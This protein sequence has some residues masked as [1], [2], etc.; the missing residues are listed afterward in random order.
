MSIVALAMAALATAV[1][2]TR[3]YA[4]GQGTAAQHARVVLAR[5]R[6]T[7]EEAAASADFPGMAVLSSQVGSFSFPDTLVVWKP[8]GNPVNPAGPPLYNELVIYCPDPA[9]PNRLLEITAPTD[10]R[11][12]PALTDTAA[13]QSNINAIK[14]SNAAVKTI[15]T[16]MLRVADAGS[17][18]SG[19]GSSQLRAALRFSVV[20]RPS[21]ADWTNY[22]NGTTAWSAL[23]WVQGINGSQAGLRQAW[24]RTELQLVSTPTTT[25]TANTEAMPFFGSAALYYELTK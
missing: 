24:C 1:R 20:I 12:T 18:T 22:K 10:T 5:I 8:T 14:T 23:N 11:T 9:A 19:T 25:A 6:N 13:W 7:V 3:S 17:G 21:Q 16:D 2:S 4:E 15:L